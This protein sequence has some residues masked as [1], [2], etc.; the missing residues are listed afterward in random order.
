[1]LYAE[2][3]ILYSQQRSRVMRVCE[4]KKRRRIGVFSHRRGEKKPA[5]VT[6]GFSLSR[7]RGNFDLAVK[8]RR[9]RARG[10]RVDSFAIIGRCMR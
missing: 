7:T 8:F 4:R 1:M 10:T 3:E 6:S 2:S 5:N 9:L